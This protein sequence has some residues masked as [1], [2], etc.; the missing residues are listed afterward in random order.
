MRQIVRQSVLHQSILW[1]LQ[2]AE[3]IVKELT[4]YIC[5][6]YILNDIN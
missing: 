3:N 6:P 5:W 4:E 1:S 2:I